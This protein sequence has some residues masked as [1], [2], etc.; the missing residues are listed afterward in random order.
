MPFCRLRAYLYGFVISACI[1]ED[2]N[3]NSLGFIV[4]FNPRQ[5]VSVCYNCLQVKQYYVYFMMNNV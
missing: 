2:H 4:S 3:G 5:L 1:I